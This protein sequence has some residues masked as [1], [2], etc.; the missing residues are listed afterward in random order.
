MIRFHRCPYCNKSNL[1]KAAPSEVGAA[2]KCRLCN[3]LSSACERCGSPTYYDEDT[4]AA[5]RKE[6][7]REEIG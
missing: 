5:C 3:E 6:E 4:C 7:I 1:R 2:F